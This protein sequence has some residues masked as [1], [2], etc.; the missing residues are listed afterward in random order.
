MIDG[1]KIL[2]EKPN[3]LIKYGKTV[4]LNESDKT[5]FDVEPD[6]EFTADKNTKQ[7]LNIILPPI[8]FYN[9]SEELCY[10]QVV[11]SPA[12][13]S[14]IVSLQKR[15]D[16]E[17]ARNQI[18]ETGICPIRE[19]LYGECFDELIRQITIN[20]SHKGIML[21]RV[22]DEMRMSIDTYQK[23]YISSLAFGLRSA[24]D[25]YDKECY[26]KGEIKRYEDEIQDLEK[27]IANMESDLEGMDKQEKQEIEQ[28]RQGFQETKST[29]EG[30]HGQLK[31]NLKEIFGLIKESAL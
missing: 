30:E 26:L 9:E 22:R 25:G 21:V 10:Q 1:A 29:A 27:E 3:T 4:I 19:K 31:D 11:N 13:I 12:R 6:R 15:L 16:E 2:P 18:R 28:I 5:D 14:D 24:F 17:L 8:F 23:L 7:I 20:C